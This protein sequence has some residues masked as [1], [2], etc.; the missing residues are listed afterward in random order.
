MLFLIGYMGCGKSTIGRALAKALGWEFVD[1]D[2]M[3]EQQEGMSIA[4][5]F[6]SKGEEY[7]RGIEAKVIDSFSSQGVVVATGGGMPCRGDNM[8][9]LNE[10]GETIYLK[11]SASKL[12]GRLDGGRK[13]RPL[14]K[15][16]NDEQLKLFI[17]DNLE[18]REKYYSKAK[19][20]IDCDGVSDSYVI[21][22][23]KDYIEHCSQ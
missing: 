14:I 8:E 11:M 23:I 19:V 20:I 4:E 2:K 9:R 7:F 12:F 3:I 13:K 17:A 21:D 18:L 22:H 5:I 1:V 10:K 15:D 6:E 16:L